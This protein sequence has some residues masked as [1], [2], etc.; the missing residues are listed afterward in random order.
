MNGE[1]TKCAAADEPTHERLRAIE[2]E[3]AAVLYAVSHDL[4]APLRAIS[5]FS[6]ALHEH[7]GDAL[8]PTAS[9]YLERIQQANRRLAEL[10]DGLLSLSRVTQAELRLQTV[11]LT[12]LC[13]QAA[14]LARTRHPEQQVK[15]ELQAGMQVSADTQT[16]QAAFE[17]LLDNAWKAT[18]QR[19]SACVEVSC[20]MADGH[21]LV[22]VQDNGL[23]FDMQYAEKLFVPFQ[24]LHA[25]GFEKGLG[26]GLA[27]VQRVVNKHG[28]RVWASS[29]PD[30]GAV[31][32]LEL[33]SAPQ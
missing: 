14:A 4:R 33:P 26:I 7:A 28:G 22:R 20:T 17:Q 12:V 19:D 30:K 27:L 1:P 29:E 15:L 11:N 16:L 2:Q 9:R 24:H 6:Q 25:S 3:L 8:D 13:T 10:I 18:A 5:G 32:F 23:G 31:F 21:S